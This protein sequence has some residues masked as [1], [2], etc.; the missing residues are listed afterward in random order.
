[1]KSTFW[2]ALATSTTMAM[3]LAGCSSG[4]SNE[5]ATTYEK[6]DTVKVGLN[7]ELSGAVASYGNAENNGAK[8]AIK[9]YNENQD[10]K[11]TIEIIEQDNKGDVSESTMAASKLIEDQVA[12]MVGPA[13]STAAIATYQTAS[14]AKVPVISPSATQVGATTNDRKETYP[15]AFRICFEDSN[16]G[17]AMA[18]YTYNTLGKKKTAILNEVS[19]YGQG[20]AEAFTKKFESMGGEVVSKESYNAGDTDFAGILTKMEQKD[21]DVLYIAGYYSEAGLIIKQARDDGATCPIVGGDGLDSTVLVDLAGE[22]YLNDVYFTTAYTTVGASDAL[23]SFISAYQEEYG[24]DPNMFSVLA[25]DATTLGLQALEEAGA[26]GE[27][28]QSSLEG[29]EFNGLT[30]NFT[31]DDTHSPIKDVLIVKMVDGVQT[32]SIKQDPEEK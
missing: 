32:E 4:Q 17:K 18:A 16:Q 5:S 2:K 15:Y 27:A 28:L 20:L 7:F 22:T 9:Q 14:D 3:M 8:L 13:T 1:M 10:S 11:Y 6:G 21:F 25:Y 31:F 12:F 19:D 29:I 24:E 23:T 30:G 26:G